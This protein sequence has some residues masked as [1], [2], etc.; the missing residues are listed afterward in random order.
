LLRLSQEVEDGFQKKLRTVLTLFNFSRAY[1]KVWRD[2][3]MVK[4]LDK[5]VGK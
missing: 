1:D 4:L 3:L 2:G 5:G